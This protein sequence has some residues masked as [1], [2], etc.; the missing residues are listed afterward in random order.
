M[1]QATAKLRA[2]AKSRAL[3]TQRAMPRPG[4]GRSSRV[5][6]RRSSGLAVMGAA[7]ALALACSPHAE[8]TESPAAAP[9]LSAEETELMD[10]LDALSWVAD[11]ADSQRHAYVISAPWCGYCQRLY[12]RSRGIEGVQLRWV[13]TDAR[14]PEHERQIAAATLTRDPA[15]LDAIYM[16]QGSLP[17]ITDPE[18]GE[19]LIAIHD[20]SVQAIVSFLERRGGRLGYPTLIYA[21]RDGVRVEPASE[22]PIAQLAAV[23]PRSDAVMGEPAAHHVATAE[24]DEQ[25]AAGVVV[26]RAEGATVRAMPHRSGARILSLEPSQGVRAQST[27]RVDGEQ[28]YAVSVFRNGGVGYVLAAESDLRAP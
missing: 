20:A 22:D 17:E 6:H 1:L 5:T 15:V 14:S 21:A 19:R 26:A 8:P 18:A 4:A 27:L 28:W 23:A 9:R 10:T 12:R 25:P 13:K 7:L 3:G 24:L 11:G 2:T 16:G